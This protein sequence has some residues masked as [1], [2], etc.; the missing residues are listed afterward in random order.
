M[1]H[2]IYER[3]FLMAMPTAAVAAFMHIISRLAM[4]LIP[5]KMQIFPFLFRDKQ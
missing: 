5:Q 2:E 3:A 4:N 1:K